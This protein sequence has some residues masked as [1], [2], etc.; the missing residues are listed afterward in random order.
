LESAAASYSL[1]AS[2]KS[3]IIPVYLHVWVFKREIYCQ[4]HR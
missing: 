3:Y 2:L 1:A 4:V